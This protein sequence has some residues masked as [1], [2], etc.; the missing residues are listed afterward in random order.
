MKVDPGFMCRF[1]MFAF[2]L[3]YSWPSSLHSLLLLVGNRFLRSEKRLTLYFAHRDSDCDAGSDSLDI[4]GDD[5]NV[6][7]EFND[8]FSSYMCFNA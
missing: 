2:I 8:A 7:D 1:F 6:G 3:P 5:G 4:T